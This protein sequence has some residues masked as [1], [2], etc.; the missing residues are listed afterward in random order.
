M[1]FV[2]TDA[3][4]RKFAE[5]GR[6]IVITHYIGEQTFDAN[7][8]PT[9][10][11]QT[12]NTKASVHRPSKRDLDIPTGLGKITMDDKKLLIPGDI[13]I[14]NA[15]TIKFSLTDEVSYIVKQVIPKETHGKISQNIVFVSKVQ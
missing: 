13:A 1:V 4:K 8:N 9:R 12:L 5:E 2:N 7:Q 10:P 14:S 11:K 3:L 6:P 15:D